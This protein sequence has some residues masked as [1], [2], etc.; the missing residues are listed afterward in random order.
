VIGKSSL[1]RLRAA[2]AIVAALVVLAQVAPGSAQTTE[3]KLREAERTA[4]KILR[5][6]KQAQAQ[7]NAIQERIEG[8]V[9][10]IE[11][12]TAQYEQLQYQ[13]EETNDEI[14]RQTDRIGELQGRLDERAHE[15][16][17]IGPAGIL[18]AILGADSL[19]EMADRVAFLDVLSRGDSAATA[20]IEGERDHLREYDDLLAG[21]V[22][23]QERVLRTLGKQRARLEK[24]FARAQAV[25]RRIERTYKEAKELV[26]SLKSQRRREL[27]AAVGAA[28]V[29]PRPGADGPFYVCPVDPPR[30]YIDSFGFPRPGGRTH[31]GNDVFAPYGTPIRAPFAGEVVE[32]SNGL[33]GITVKVYASNGDWVYNAHMSRYAGVSGFV[34]AGTVIGYVGD[35]GNAAGTPPH[36]HFEY[37]P[38][39]GAVSPY[40]Y[41]NEVCGVGGRGP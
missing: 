10:H 37:H 19:S 36:D 29:G 30:S 22:Q 14:A 17:K 13:I 16:Y 12:A 21:Y 27:L 28:N 8:L 11:Q 33:G 24:E 7:R 9:R 2:L 3:H 6:L 25:E 32:D 35:S 1:G 34:N 15:A 20:A 5:E 39:G 41:L 23:E 31:Q 38:G 18:E 40:V 4:R 26:G